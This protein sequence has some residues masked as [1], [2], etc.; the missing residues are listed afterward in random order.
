[1]KKRS[2]LIFGLLVFIVLAG[3]GAGGYYWLKLINEPPEVPLYANMEEIQ[4][5]IERLEGLRLETNGL[6]WQD[7]FILG[8]AYIQ[9]RMFDEA[10]TTL[11]EAIRLKPGFHKSY[12]SLGMAYFRL[13]E[14]EKAVKS[15]EEAHR[16]RPEATHLEE[17][18]DRAERKRAFE[19]RVSALEKAVEKGR[20]GWRNRLELASLYI[21]M[22]RVEDAKAHLEEA[23]KEKK[24]SPELYDALAQVH[25]MGGDF[26]KAV[27]AEKMAVRLNPDDEAMKKRLEE[28]EKFIGRK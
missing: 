10:V 26:D 11:E 27:E 6:S 24:D 21:A 15:W 25:A 18:I 28:L 23:L 4:R 20:A 19:N 14:L 9:A 22:K 2:L 8:V 3:A 5:D 16:M 7:T 12:E 17:M 13:G 1:M